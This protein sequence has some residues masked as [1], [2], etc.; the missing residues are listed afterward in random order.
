MNIRSHRFIKAADEQQKKLKS[1]RPLCL[2]EMRRALH[3]GFRENEE[4]TLASM[5]SQVSENTC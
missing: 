1:E 3:A 2:T 5:F 4:G